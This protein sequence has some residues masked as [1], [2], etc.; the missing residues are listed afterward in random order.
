M[1][2]EHE[3]I[4]RDPSKILKNISSPINI[5]LKY[6]KAPTPTYLM[7]GS[8]INGMVSSVGNLTYAL[9]YL[10]KLHLN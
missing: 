3:K 6:F 9:Y 8:L 4:S 1:K 10:K 5:C 2:I 7:F